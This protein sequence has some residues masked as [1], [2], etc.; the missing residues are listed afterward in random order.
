[1]TKII[2]EVCQN[3]LG[4]RDI[5]KKMVTEAAESGADFIKMQSIFSEDLTHR[6]RFDEGETNAD[7]TVKVI[8]RPYEA[9]KERLAKLDLTID[10]HLFFIDACRQAGVI[11]FTTI[12]ARKRIPEIAALPWPGKY[13]KVASYDCASL[14]MLENLCA[15]FDNLIVSTGATYDQE[16][17]DAATLL[18]KSGKQYSFL[19]CVTSYPNTLA[20]CNLSR[21]DWL[22]AYAP[23][24]GW[25]DH[26]LVERD[27]IIASKVALLLGADFIERHF[28]VLEK[29]QTKDGP[30][31]IRPEHIREL[32]RF[33]SLT[34]QEQRS[35]LDSQ[36][37]GWEITLGVPTREMTP[38]ELLNRDYYRGRFASLVQGEWKYNWE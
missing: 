13:I 10:D 19:H 29:D 8:K 24:V 4:S 21:M 35:E 20:M 26:T 22:R 31:S 38:T 12:F 5:L 33:R 2:V 30:V 27:G 18:K 1:M 6:P 16:I 28:T 37:T 32:V 15:H 9:E 11:P 36:H 14:P 17:A 7:G 3:H 23:R 34:P 25:S